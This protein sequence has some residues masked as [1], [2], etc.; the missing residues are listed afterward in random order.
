MAFLVQSHAQ[1]KPSW[2]LDGE[3]GKSLFSSV[4]NVL[5]FGS[6]ELSFLSPFLMHVQ[7]LVKVLWGRILPLRRYCLLSTVL[8][9]EF[10]SAFPAKSPSSLY[11]SSTQQMCYREHWPCVWGISRFQSVILTHVAIK[12][13]DFFG[14]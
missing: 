6:F 14:P 7:N 9:W 4:Q 11:N 3:P 2:V 12:N 5:S 10:L 1:V 8:L 13:S